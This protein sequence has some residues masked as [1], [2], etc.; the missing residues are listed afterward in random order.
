MLFLVFWEPTD[1]VIPDRHRSISLSCSETTLLMSKSDLSPM[2]HTPFT[3]VGANTTPQ[4]VIGPFVGFANG[5]GGALN[6]PTWQSFGTSYH[7]TII[8][9]RNGKIFST[10][11]VC[12]LWSAF[13]VGGAAL[14][15][16][17]Y[18]IQPI[19]DQH[20]LYFCTIRLSILDP[21]L[22]YFCTTY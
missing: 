13:I 18:G 4:S 15:L 1:L 22:L 9:Q 3:A 14:V 10:Q 2:E 11:I 8:P 16:E 6:S 17:N 7:G 5:A 12:Q 21:Q 20:L 19:L